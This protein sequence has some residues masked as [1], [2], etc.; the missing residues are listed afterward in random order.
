[1]KITEIKN[2]L[3]KTK[4]LKEIMEIHVPNI[5]KN[6][7]SKNG[8]IY[9]IIGAPESVHLIYYLVHLLIN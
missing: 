9:A 6:L 7:P 5:D 2:N 8:S 3:P 1:M 4:A